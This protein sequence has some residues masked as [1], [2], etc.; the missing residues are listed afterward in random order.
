LNASRTSFALNAGASRIHLNE[1]PRDV[2]LLQLDSR[3]ARIPRF[4][5]NVDRPELTADHSLF[6]AIEIGVTAGALAQIVCAD[7]H[8]C[9]SVLANYPREV[10]V[11]IDEW[12]GRENLLR[13]SKILVSCLGRH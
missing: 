8:R 2:E 1:P 9:D 6:Q 11:S 13:A 5:G 10:V 3:V 4:T 12:R 7:V